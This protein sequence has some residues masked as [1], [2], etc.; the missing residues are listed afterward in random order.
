MPNFPFTTEFPWPAPA[1][2]NLFLH[3]IGR[4]ADG[5]HNLQTVFQFL[6]FGDSLFF[7]PRGDGVIRRTDGPADIPEDQDLV[8]RAA[9]ALK[10]ASGAGLGADIAVTKRIPMGGGLGGGSSDAATTLVALNRLWNIG[11]TI[12]ELATIG[13]KLGADVP[14]FVRGLAAW[15]EGVG[16]HLRPLNLPEPYYLVVTPPVAVSTGEI[17][18]APELP[19]ASEPITAEAFLGGEGQNDCEAVTC[20]RYPLVREALDWLRQFGPARMSGT[21]ASVFLACPSRAEARGLQDQV[22]KGWHSFVAAGLNQS[23]LGTLA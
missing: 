17:F 14:V 18:S 16:E 2:L 3:V 23:P 8:V 4:R 5:Y 6:D 15:A 11:L 19:R 22:P 10:S 12:D 13:L 20:A 7:V 21:G 1:K 9:H